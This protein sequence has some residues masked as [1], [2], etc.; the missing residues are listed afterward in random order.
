MWWKIIIQRFFIAIDEPNGADKSTFIDIIKD[1]IECEDCDRYITK[2]LTQTELGSFLRRFEEENTG[3]RLACMIVAD[4]YELIRNEMFPELIKVE[5]L[6]R[7]DKVSFMV[8]IS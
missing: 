6:L 4:R 8:G 7:T 5:L 3:I 2:E 1:K